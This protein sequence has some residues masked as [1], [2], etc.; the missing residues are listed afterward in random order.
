[1]FRD[2]EHIAT[3]GLPYW[4]SAVILM[5][6]D[7]ID[8]NSL[9]G[10][11]PSA[12]STKEI[13]NQFR[14]D[15]EPFVTIS[16]D[17]LDELVIGMQLDYFEVIGS[18]LAR[19][20]LFVKDELQTVVDIEFFFSEMAEANGCA[21]VWTNSGKLGWDWLKECLLNL[22]D[23]E[24]Q[25]KQQPEV[26]NEAAWEPLAL[27]YNSRAAD[28]ATE[29]LQNAI[30]AIA[31]DNGYASTFPAERNNVL[32]LL[33]SSLGQMQIR[34]EYTRIYFEYSLI[35]PLNQAVYRLGGNAAGEIAK[36]A[37]LALREWAKDIVRSVIG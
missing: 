32:A 2:S 17:R 22:I 8:P 3:A 35:K 25:F 27:D 29:A 19:P 30:D 33:R 34:A 15:S 14:R 12:I 4:R 28:A 16:L 26:S 13:W 20:R 24:S 6:R 5:L 1:M 9:P 7:L 37:L 21:A 18:E 36:G 10:T 23:A 11:R 31:A